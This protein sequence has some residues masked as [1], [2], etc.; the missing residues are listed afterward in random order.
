MSKQETVLDTLKKMAKNGLSKAV[1]ML[2]EAQSEDYLRMEERM[3]KIE[4]RVE[5]VEKKIDGVSDKMDRVLLMLEVKKAPFTSIK[6]LFSNK[7]FLFL[8][9]ILIS[10]GFGMSLQDIVSAWVKL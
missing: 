5:S 2:A 10:L 1:L 4:E 7:L 9:F 6:E 8:M 3:T